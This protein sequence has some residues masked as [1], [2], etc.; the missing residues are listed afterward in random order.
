MFLF[1]KLHNNLSYFFLSCCALS[2]LSLSGCNHQAESENR[3]VFDSLSEEAKR[4]PEN[5]VAGLEVAPDLAVTLFASEPMMVNPTNM[6]IDSRGRVWICEGYNYR[7]VQNPD[8]PTKP[9]GD[10]ILIMEDT[11]GD[12]KADTSTVFYQGNDINAALGICVLGNKVI[13]SRSPDVFLFTDTDGDDKADKKEVLFTGIEGVQHDHAIHAFTFGPDGKL[14]FNFGNAGGHLM[15]KDGKPVTEQTHTNVADEGKPYRQG[16]VFRC[17]PDGSD[18]EV[19]GNNFRNNYEVAVDSYGTLWQSD[20]DDDGNKGVRINYVMEYGNFGYTDEMTGENW[21]TYRTGMEEE[22]PKR[23]W[24][25]NDPGVV[26]N[27]LQT[28]AGSPT[29]MVIYEGDLLPERFHNQIIHA[30]AGPNVVRAYPVTNDGAGYSAKIENI[31]QGKDQWFRPAD[32]CIA[33]DGSLFIADWYDPGVGGHQMGD[34]QRGRVYRV[35]PKDTPYKIKQPDLSTPE[36]AAEALKSPN[37]SVRYL[38]WTQLHDWGTKAEP[39]LQQMLT[40]DHQRYRARAFWLLSKIKGKGEQYVQQALE[41]SSADIRIL[42]I[43]MA[44][45]LDM[46]IIPVIQQVVHDDSPQVRREAALALRYQDSPQANDLWA[47]LATQHDGKDRW[48]LEALGIGADMYPEQ[49]YQAW[50]KKVNDNWDTP[51]GR[52]VVW[53]LRAKETIPL[54]ASIIEESESNS[55][56]DRLRYFRA[57]DFHQDPSKQKVLADLALAQH[58]N[59]EAITLLA[60]NHLD[61]NVVKQSPRLKN[62]LTTSLENVRGSKEYL[63]L[64]KRYELKNY[65]KDLLSLALEKPED[66]LSAEAMSLLLDLGGKPLVEH[67]FAT[68]DEEMKTK[69]IA[70]LK[71][72]NNKESFDILQAVITSKKEALPVRQEAVMAFA[73]SWGGEEKLLEIV[74]SGDMNSDLDSV[75]AH[76]LSMSNRSAIY[77]E[78]ASLLEMPGGGDST[79]LAP[80]QQ[81]ITMK[82]DPDHGAAVFARTCQNCH[83]VNGKGVDFGPALSEIGGKLPKEGL[84]DAILNPSSGISFG[85][86]G[87]NV[88]L[89]DGSQV[90]GYIVNKTDEQLQLKMYGGL[91]NTYE[92]AN[93]SSMEPM[94][95]SLMFDN[96]E[97]A[98]TQQELVDLVEYLT[99]LK[100]G[101]NSVS[102][103]ESK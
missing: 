85:Y 84:Y 70:T 41:D 36:K 96:L 10:R 6:D 92:M 20:N 89:K 16:M 47:E 74:K 103:R 77:Q 45:E 18:F 51:E 11:D 24:H 5:A 66:E 19:L 73:G 39:V 13:V 102:M 72:V 37:L 29:G 64:I 40:S 23:H 49:R 97:R 69:A 67:V 28:G 80:V 21:R 14:Y 98:M 3:I 95:Q 33:P 25:L 22:I 101:N 4:L 42:G 87:Y 75:A 88:K 46:D 9:E 60:L 17:N 81:L 26:P 86:E 15:D 90:T 61:V 68:K 35:A 50:M 83:A 55:N 79:T 57:F 94:E 38:A 62:A 30:D 34:Q 52:D 48:Y 53:R 1:S 76:V 58:P 71:R 8:N 27:L 54:L 65:N 12:G 93:V 2:L 44:S 59:K 56:H 82:G 91:T 31:V 43:R 100:K 63:E 99:T 78:A 7:P 32:V